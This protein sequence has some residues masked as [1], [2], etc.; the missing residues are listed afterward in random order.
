MNPYWEYVRTGYV[1]VWVVLAAYSVS[2]AARQRT[3]ERRADGP[4]RRGG[5]GG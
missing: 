5:A 4:D 2:L 3:A 1:L